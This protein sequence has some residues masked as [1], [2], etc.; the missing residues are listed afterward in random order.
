MF[1]IALSNS[2]LSISVTVEKAIGYTFAPRD[3]NFSESLLV[4][5]CVPVTPI[6]ILSSGLDIVFEKSKAHT[7]PTTIMAG[8]FTALF[9]AFSAKVFSV[10]LIV[11]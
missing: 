10:A 8:D 6:F 5:P 9:F 3:S 1:I 7:S 4:K 11:S 2:L